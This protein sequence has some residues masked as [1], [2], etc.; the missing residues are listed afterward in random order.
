MIDAVF[1]I[2]VADALKDIT[3]EADVVDISTRGDFAGQY[4]KTC[5]AEGFCCNTAHRIASDASVKNG[6][7]DLVGNLVGMPFAHR[8]GGKEK[9]T[10]HEP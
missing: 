9:F 8:F 7:R 4:H 3:S 6:I 5:R 10:A 2:V 1:G